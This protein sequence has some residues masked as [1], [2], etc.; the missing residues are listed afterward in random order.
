[1]FTG[2]NIKEAL[3]S[4]VKGYIHNVSPIKQNSRNI[5]WFDCSFQMEQGVVRA[6]CF[7]PSPST[8]QRFT[9]AANN[10][11][12]VKLSNFKT[13]GKKEGGPVDIII[14]PKNYSRGYQRTHAI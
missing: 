8:L 4:D 3:N 12:S 9:Q 2:P 11:S 1:M 6:V 5:K 10:Q 14:P 7:D 13:G